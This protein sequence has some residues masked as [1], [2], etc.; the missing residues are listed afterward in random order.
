MSTLLL[1]GCSF[2]KCWQ[3]TK[4]FLKIL[5][6]DTIK[7]IAV[8]GSSFQR[9]VRTT[10][11]WVAQNGNPSFVIIPITFTHRWE[12]AIGNKDN[13][14]EGSWIPIQ[15]KEFLNK[16]KISNLVDFK[17]LENLID[18]YYGSIPDIK[19][20]WDQCFTNIISI[21]SFLQNQKN[22]YLLF[23]I[24]NNF[25]KKHLKGYKG[26]EKIKLIEQNKKIIDLFNFCG[27]KHMWN[28][29]NDQEKQNTDS[30]S[31]HHNAYQYSFLEN[32][33][34]NYLQSQR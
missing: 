23:D 33:L 20:Y 14:I 2:T 17:K 34:I 27:N 16:N 29:M 18:L 15:R 8:D 19:T 25:V 5:N 21:S 31:H 26:F 3:P 28:S 30:L 32:Y 22:N 7:N 10:I 9:S 4:N 13:D 6:C 1:N 12:L 24:C 11:E